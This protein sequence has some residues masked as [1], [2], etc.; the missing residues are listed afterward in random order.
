MRFIQIVFGLT[1]RFL[2]ILG[3]GM[4]TFSCAPPLEHSHQGT[5]IAIWGISFFVIGAV[6]VSAE[7]PFE[8]EE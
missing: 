3:L 2:L 6:G 7:A 1:N 8:D 5:L 4:L